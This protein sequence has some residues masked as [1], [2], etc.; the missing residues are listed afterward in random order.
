MNAPDLFSPSLRSPSETTSSI[1]SPCRG[2]EDGNAR[3]RRPD[4]SDFDELPLELPPDRPSLALLGTRGI[5]AR[6]GGY[7]TFAEELSV[8]LVRRGFDVTVFCPRPAGPAPLR[9]RGVRL[10]YV[11][12][13]NLGSAGSLL[14]DA[15]C[16]ARA[17]RGFDVVYML[18]YGASPFCFLPRLGGAK[19]WINMD[20][21]EWKRAKWKGLPRLWLKLVEALSFRTAS[22]L[23]FDNGAVARRIGGGRRERTPRRVIEYGAYVRRHPEADEILARHGL[24]R[25]GYFF[26]LAR[27]EP[28][29]QLLEIVR[30][31]ERVDTDRELV[32][33]TNDHC[34]TDYA[35]EFT[36]LCRGRVRRLGAIYDPEVLCALR[37][38]ATAC[39]H[40]H[41]VGGTN[42]ALLEAMGCGA[43]I[44]AHDNEFNREVLQEAGRYFGSETDLTLR[45]AELE[46]L[47]ADDRRRLEAAA[48]ERVRSHYSWERITD[49]YA[50]LLLEDA[51]ES[52]SEAAVAPLARKRAS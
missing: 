4:V 7:E 50:D 13:P 41:T 38:H 44:L 49:L 10:E 8:R 45:L 28:E 39:I 19:V 52:A 33:V 20:G 31:F 23:I 14:F 35:R 51:S 6:Y 1:S 47:A 16:L 43:V 26:T 42:P 12:S 18:G 2:D 36:S 40:G 37:G 17:R 5:P 3:D 9:H 15:A 32:I 48:R 34:G 29:N 27:C 22:R 21:I 24:T 30:A 25:G 11:G 46:T